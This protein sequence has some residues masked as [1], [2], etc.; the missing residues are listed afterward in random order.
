MSE[1]LADQIILKIEQA[2]KN[3]H[4]LLA[5]VAPVGEGKTRAFQEVHARTGAPLLNVNLEL[6]RLMLDLTGRQRVLQLPQLLAG[7]INSVQGDVILLDNI[8]LLFDPLLKQDPLRLLQGI[9]RNKTLV[10]SW[11]GSVDDH[12]LIYATPDHAEYR[13]Y[14]KEDI[15]IVTVG[16]TQ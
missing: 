8:E 12:H 2:A 10:V 14:P 5:V 4:R 13:R 11:S 15:L 3:Y 7:R 1:P 16:K 9:S 6:S